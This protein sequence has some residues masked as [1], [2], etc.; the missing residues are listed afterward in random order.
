M[1]CIGRIPKM[2]AKSESLTS[3]SELQVVQREVHQG[4]RLSADDALVYLVAG[5]N[6]W[7]QESL[8]NLYNHMH[9]II[10]INF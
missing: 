10:A 9:M 3:W 4:S 7:P 8:H 6:V 1:K 5:V 2:L